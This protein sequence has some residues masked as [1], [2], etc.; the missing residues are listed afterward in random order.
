M[1]TPLLAGSRILLLLHVHLCEMETHSLGLLTN[2]KSVHSQA[3]CSQ[4][5]HLSGCQKCCARCWP[6]PPRACLR[7]GMSFC[8][9]AHRGRV[10]GAETDRLPEQHDTECRAGCSLREPRE[11]LARRAG[12]SE[13]AALASK[14]LCPFKLGSDKQAAGSVEEERQ[15][16][17]ERL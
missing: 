3:L 11:Q 15:R 6:A 4:S 7:S 2:W 1:F 17:S 16:V 12:F 10:A 9:F 8:R 13:R 5:A 14:E